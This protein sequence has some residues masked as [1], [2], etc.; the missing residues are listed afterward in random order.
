MCCS[1]L[2]VAV[3]ELTEV[4]LVLF[5]VCVRV[6]TDGADYGEVWKSSPADGVVIPRR[7]SLD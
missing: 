3:K 7:R 1:V 2:L 6:D 5:C 4:S